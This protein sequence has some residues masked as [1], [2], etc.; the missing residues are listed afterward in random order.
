[1]NMSAFL[2][3][4]YVG[5]GLAKGKISS[6]KVLTMLCVLGHVQIEISDLLELFD[7]SNISVFA[8]L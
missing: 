6:L 5:S 4:G 1:M 7:L 3:I 2:S 8:Y